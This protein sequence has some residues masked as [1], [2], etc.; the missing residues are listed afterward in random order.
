MKIQTKVKTKNRMK[1]VFIQ[2]LSVFVYS[3]PLADFHH[4]QTLRVFLQKRNHFSSDG[5]ANCL[6]ADYLKEHLIRCDIY[7]IVNHEYFKRVLSTLRRIS[8]CLYVPFL[9]VLAPPLTTL[10][11]ESR[12]IQKFGQKTSSFHYLNRQDHCISKF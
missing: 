2:P 8:C 5:S 9:G 3:I 1:S 6:I 11:Y 12:Q 10:Q 7:V 4:T